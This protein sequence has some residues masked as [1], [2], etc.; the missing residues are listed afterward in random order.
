MKE[1]DGIMLCP[2]CKGCYKYMSREEYN[3]FSPMYYLKSYD[4]YKKNM[5]CKECDDKSKEKN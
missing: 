1:E 3:V 4:T 2:E 5:M